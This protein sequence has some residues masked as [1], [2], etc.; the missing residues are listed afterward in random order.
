MSLTLY[1]LRHGQTV[2]SRANAY[3]GS[4]D[5]ELTPFGL[6]MAQAVNNAYHSTPWN[7][8]FCSPM[9]RTIATAKP[10]SEALGMQLD[11]RD[12]LK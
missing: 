12:G 6:D 2:F 1:L 8:I 7:A 11:L 4:L 10:L 3:C 5:P 9:Q